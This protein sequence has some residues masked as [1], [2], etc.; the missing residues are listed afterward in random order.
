MQTLNKIKTLYNCTN[1][2]DVGFTS[3]ACNAKSH[4]LF[5]NCTKGRKLAVDSNSTKRR[6]H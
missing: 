5:C 2:Y 4:V 3:L 1:C 6:I